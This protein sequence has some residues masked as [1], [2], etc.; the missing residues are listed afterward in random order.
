M[1]GG[2]TWTTQNNQPTAQFYHVATDNAYPYHIYGAQQDNSNVGIAS[3]SE[4]GVI[5][6]QNWFVAGAA[7]AAS[8]CLIR[9]TGTLFIPTTRATSLD[10]IRT[11]KKDRT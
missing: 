8:S 1:D 5:T 11:R 4:E 7:S 2:K 10:T 3:R 6:A 9:A